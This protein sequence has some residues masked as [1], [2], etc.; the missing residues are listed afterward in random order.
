MIK[1]VFDGAST[2]NDKG[3][4]LVSVSSKHPIFNM[5][6]RFEEE[7]QLNAELTAK[8]ADLEKTVAAT[9]DQG[10]FSG[11]I[12]AYFTDM[13]CLVR[14]RPKRPGKKKKK[15]KATPNA[16]EPSGLNLHDGNVE[17]QY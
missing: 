5:V 4:V 2:H 1:D 7:L 8:V 6:Q 17:L 10:E 15:N 9:T 3:L 12:V 13:H 14:D 11:S 16:S